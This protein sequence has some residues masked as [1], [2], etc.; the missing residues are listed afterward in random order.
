[1][2][3]SLSTLVWLTL[4]VALLAWPYAE[5]IRLKQQQ[6]TSN[7]WIMTLGDRTTRM[8]YK[9]IDQQFKFDLLKMQVDQLE[10]KLKK[11]R[12]PGRAASRHGL[13]FWATTPVI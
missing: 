3:F 8:T 9:Q 10:R 4:T 11:R 7:D 13:R 5:I 1:M 12:K 2:K 6:Q